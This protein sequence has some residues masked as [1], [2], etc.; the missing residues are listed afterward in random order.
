MCRI[1]PC[2]LV[3]YPILDAHYEHFAGARVEINVERMLM[4]G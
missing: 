4:C 2:R 3:A 1:L